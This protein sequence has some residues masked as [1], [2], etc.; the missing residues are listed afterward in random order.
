MLID[1]PTVKVAPSPQVAPGSSSHSQPIQN[2]SSDSK[3]KDPIVTM[4]A[5]SNI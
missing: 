3:A 1:D 2:Q 5:Q 4:P